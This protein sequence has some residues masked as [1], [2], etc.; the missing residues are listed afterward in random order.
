VSSRSASGGNRPALAV[1]GDPPAPDRDRI[2][3]AKRAVAIVFGVNGFLLGS[4]VATA[5]R[6]AGP[7]TLE[8]ADLRTDDVQ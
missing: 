4:W 2:E 7:W 6:M 5:A 3:R 8:T 1:T